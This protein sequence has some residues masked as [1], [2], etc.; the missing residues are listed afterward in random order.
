MGANRRI[1]VVLTC[2][3]LAALRAAVNAATAGEAGG[4]F[5]AAQLRQLIGIGNKLAVVQWQE[6][7][8]KWPTEPDR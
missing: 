4:D 2:Q 6:F 8:G 5:T 3:E 7:G 1:E